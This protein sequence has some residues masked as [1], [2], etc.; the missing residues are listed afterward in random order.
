M[1]IKLDLGCGVAP[2]KDHVGV[3]Q[4]LLPSVDLVADLEAALPFRTN[5]VDGI[6]S[7][8]VLEHLD[9]F[10]F[11]MAEIH[12]VLKPGAV[13][14]I[15]VPHF[16]SPLSFS[17]FTHKRFFGYYTFD[18]LVP[19]SEQKSP[20]KV[21]EHYTTFKFRIL[22]KRLH[23]VSYFPP[24]MAFYWLFEKLVNSSEW[25]A[26]FYES[27]LCYLLPCYSIEISLTPAK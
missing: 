14:H 21:P 7:K 6:Y 3:D 23:F 25:L 26:L 9:R 16:S 13:I 12:R 20:R 8:S 17:D 27:T 4:H 18:Y 19:I 2:L 24:M 5:S 22:S 1:T 11:V 10:E 15:R